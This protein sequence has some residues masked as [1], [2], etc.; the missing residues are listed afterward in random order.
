M[1]IM[2]KNGKR[3]RSHNNVH[4]PGDPG[5]LAGVEADMAHPDAPRK[6]KPRWCPKCTPDRCTGCQYIARLCTCPGGARGPELAAAR[7]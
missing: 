1:L 5:L 4:T 2:G 7:S 3:S 6:R